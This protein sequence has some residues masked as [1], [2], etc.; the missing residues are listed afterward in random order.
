MGMIKFTVVT[1]ETTAAVT[2]SFF[3]QVPNSKAYYQ[4]A[5]V[6]N[7]IWRELEERP[8]SANIVNA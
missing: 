3:F 6:L 5:R 2:E 4:S 1:T 8:I 7:E